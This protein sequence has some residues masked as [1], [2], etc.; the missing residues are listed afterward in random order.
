MKDSE[1]END[2]EAEK[3]GEQQAVTQIHT[4]QTQ[5]GV[6]GEAGGGQCGDHWARWGCFNKGGSG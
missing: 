1:G 5:I 3:E 4:T 2:G 6:W